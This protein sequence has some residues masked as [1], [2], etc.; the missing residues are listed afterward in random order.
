MY[1]GK[2]ASDEAEKLYDDTLKTINNLNEKEAKSF[3][4]LIYAKIDIV[5]HGNGKYSSKECI[6]ELLEKFKNLNEISKKE[7]K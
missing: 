1:K 3:L 5:K 2:I 7:K 6:S 4:K